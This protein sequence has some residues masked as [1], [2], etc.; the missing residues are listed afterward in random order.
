MTEEA[1]YFK[2]LTALMQSAY[3]ESPHLALSLMQLRLMMSHHGVGI[4]TLAKNAG[5]S[6]SWAFKV[7]RGQVGKRY[8]WGWLNTF[9]DVMH[10]IIE[11]RGG[12]PAACCGQ[13]AYD[14]IKEVLS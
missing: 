9:D 14:A 1:E 5:C 8:I 2:E 10:G 3:V 11:S 4:A 6:R 12:I 13:A 7:M